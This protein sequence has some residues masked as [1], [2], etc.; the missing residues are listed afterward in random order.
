MEYEPFTPFDIYPEILSAPKKFSVEN[1]AGDIESWGDLS[2][3]FS[4]LYEGRD[5]LPDSIKLKVNELTKNEKDTLKKI[6][7]LYHYLQNNTRYM[8]IQL[9]IGGWQTMTAMEVSRKGYGDCKALSNYMKALLKEVGV[10]SIIAL[11]KAGSNEELI[12]P[13]FPN[14]NFNHVIN[15]VPLKKDTIWLE[16]TS[17]NNAMGYQGSFTGNRKA[18]LILPEGGTL[19]NTCK[20]SPLDNTQSRKATL[21]VDE[22]G[23]AKA[24]IKTVYKGIE[25][26]N[27]NYILHKKN[28]EQQ[29]KILQNRIPLNSFEID[30]FYLKETKSR[31]PELE[32]YLNLR[33]AKLANQTGKRFFLKP[34]ILNRTFISLPELKTRK[35]PFYLNPT[36]FNRQEIDSLNFNMP[37]NFETEFIPVPISINTKFGEYAITIH[38]K[39]GV[40]SYYRKLMLHEGYFSAAE[41]TEWLD[42]ISKINKLDQLQ[43]AF[44]IKKE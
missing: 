33:I 8:S 42:F 13:D 37:L 30:N 5:V 36:I 20:Y 1:Y 28:I 9:G 24:Q 41:Y 2:K 34:N 16:C 35:Q 23:N 15:C 10:S 25:Q 40:L 44:K 43:I 7:I 6:E 31:I 32:E 17:Q 26:E 14:A 29:K 18:L 21:F 38:F 27:E 3:F 22:L 11:I 19:V 12:E 4:K 39:N